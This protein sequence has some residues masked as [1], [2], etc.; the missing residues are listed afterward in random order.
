MHAIWISKV[1]DGQQSVTGI[2]GTD[3]T[4]QVSTMKEHIDVPT[5]ADYSLTSATTNKNVVD[6]DNPTQ[7]QREICGQN[8]AAK[9][10]LDTVDLLS[11]S[12]SSSEV[13]RNAW[14]PREIP[15]GIVHVG[16]WLCS[17]AAASI[18][19]L[20]ALWLPSAKVLIGEKCKN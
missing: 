4:L 3:D 10:C 12:S 11:H 1:P 15:A 14:D 16:L 2:T 5:S 20:D 8:L 9:E 6:T 13:L 18:A 7:V 17:N 19:T